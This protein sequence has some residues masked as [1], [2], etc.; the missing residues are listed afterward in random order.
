MG[1]FGAPCIPRYQCGDRVDATSG[2][3]LNLEV[4]GLIESTSNNAWHA[5]ASDHLDI[6]GFGQIVA[7]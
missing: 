2:A 7:C 1:L 3:E 5:C 4:G 6:G